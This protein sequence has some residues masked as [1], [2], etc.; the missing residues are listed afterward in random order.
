[1]DFNVLLP[2][3]SFENAGPGHCTCMRVWTITGY[4]CRK[5][6]LWVTLEPH[7]NNSFKYNLIDHDNRLPGRFGIQ[8]WPFQRFLLFLRVIPTHCS[9]RYTIPTHNYKY[10]LTNQALD[11]TVYRFSLHNSK[12]IHKQ[13]ND[14]KSQIT[15]RQA[16]IESALLFIVLIMKRNPVPLMLFIYITYICTCCTYTTPFQRTTVF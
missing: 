13:Q 8:K 5:G 9:L 6:D 2:V 1:M 7:V 15:T 14:L 3:K 10:V 4:H 16:H 12:H 11:D